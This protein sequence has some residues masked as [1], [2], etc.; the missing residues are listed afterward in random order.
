[1]AE[2]KTSIS[3]QIKSPSGVSEIRVSNPIPGLVIPGSGISKSEILPQKKEQEKVFV[4]AVDVKTGQSL[5]QIENDKKIIEEVK[6]ELKGVAG[7]KIVEPIPKFIQTPSEV[8]NSNTNGSFI[9][10]G[11]DRP[12][13]RLSGY[14]GKGDTKAASI[15]IVVGRQGSEAK[16]VNEYD[17]ELYVD[18][19]FEKDAARI[20]ISQKSDI[21]DYFKIVDGSVGNIKTR[22][23][24]G[25]KADGIRIIGREGVKI[26]TGG[27]K[28]NSQGGAIK[29]ISGIDLIAGND[30]TDLQSMVKGENLKQALERVVE[31]LNKLSGIVDAFLHTQMEYN[32][33]ISTHWH[34]SPFF[35]IP[36]LPSEVLI[37]EGMKCSMNQLIK[38]KRSLVNFKANLAGFKITYLNSWGKK[39]I[40]SRYNKLN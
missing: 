34:S 22:S 5:K 13:N 7:D 11:R 29:S 4:P 35:A 33:H 16:K 28:F 8:I 3:K 25:L 36:T 27:D 19:D 15:D 32:A 24:I 12:G 10:L 40:N 39:Y 23:S 14:G 31:H 37:P 18:N 2:T 17:E 30:D 1:M 21:D 6:E 20:Y 9:V 38:V 26:I